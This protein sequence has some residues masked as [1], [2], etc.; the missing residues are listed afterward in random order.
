VEEH[1]RPSDKTRATEQED[2]Q[3]HAEADEMPTSDEE[4][5]AERAGDVDEDVERNYKDAIERGADQKG[6]GRIP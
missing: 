1:T 3:V 6:E 5:A 4:A 2:A